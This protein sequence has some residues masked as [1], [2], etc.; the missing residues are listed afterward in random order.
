MS[1]AWRG[2]RPEG[3]A[4]GRASKGITGGLASPRAVVVC[5]FRVLSISSRLPLCGLGRDSVHKHTQ[6]RNSTF[7]NLDPSR[8]VV[9]YI[10]LYLHLSIIYIKFKLKVA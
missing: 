7:G 2:T 5:F 8:S 9:T 10:N 6:R 4:A 3:A 1:E